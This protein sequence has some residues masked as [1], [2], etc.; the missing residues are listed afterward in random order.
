[1]SKFEG[2]EVCAELIE[3]L[4]A[5]AERGVDVPQ[6]VDLLQQR[7]EL[8]ESNAVLPAIVYFRAAFALSLREA[9]PLREWL[10]GRD[11][12]EIDSVLIP[13]MQRSKSR[14]QAREVLPTT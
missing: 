13:A 4:R 1:M 5:L 11:R 6:L 2:G 14:W 10:G 7:L 3:E 12:T 8:D 9:M